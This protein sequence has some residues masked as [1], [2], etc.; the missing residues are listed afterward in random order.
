MSRYGKAVRA[1]AIFDAS[2]EVM[3]QLLTRQ[4]MMDAIGR[5]RERGE[6]E[7]V[8][9]LIRERENVNELVRKVADA[10]GS[11]DVLMGVPQELIDAMVIRYLRNREIFMKTYPEGI[12]DI[13][14]DPV[15]IWAAIMISPRDENSVR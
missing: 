12:E 10:R 11:R 3:K 6:D 1:E 9:L 14:A 7:I 2:V 5:A 4:E 8:K 15:S 13:D